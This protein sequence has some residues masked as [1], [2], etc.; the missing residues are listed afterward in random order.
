M[1]PFWGILFLV[2]VYK[3]VQVKNKKIAGFWLL[4]VAS[5]FGVLG[6]L[7]FLAFIGFSLIA[8]VFWFI[9][10]PTKINW[11]FW[12]GSLLLL[13]FLYSPMIIN[14]VKY[15]GNNFDHFIYSIK[16]KSENKERSL[17]EKIVKSTK[18]A[19]KFTMF[20]VVSTNDNEIKINDLLGIFFISCGLLVLLWQIKIHKRSSSRDKL[21]F[22]V[23]LLI[24]F[25]VFL[26]LYTKAAYSL[27]KARFWLPVF[28]L[29]FIFLALIFL[30]IW[31]IKVRSI[32]AGKFLVFFIT[33]I[34][35]TANLSAIG[36]W[37]A[38]LAVK[39]EVWSFRK[40]SSTSLRQR[41]LIT[42]GEMEQVADHI[43]SQTKSGDLIC[44]EGSRHER[45][46]H[47]YLIIE[48][49]SDRTVKLYDFEKHLFSKEELDACSSF[50]FVGDKHYSDEKLKEKLSRQLQLKSKYSTGVM[51]I[52]Q[53]EYNK[54]EKED[55]LQGE[56]V[57]DVQ[58]KKKNQNNN[59]K[60]EQVAPVRLPALF[61]KDLFSN[62]D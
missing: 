25:L 4:I 58:T 44:L 23:L 14:D 24:W 46:T 47:A 6:Q 51:E 2:A 49:D 8:I 26:I 35:L 3:T 62:S 1:I 37:Y 19:G 45:K 13:L 11:K 59:K 48:K 34:L 42:L 27:N 29:V 38:S 41:N 57:V 55:V 40:W 56:S 54:G 61:W 33:V 18:E 17:G 52:Y 50:F 22:L 36:K 60:T 5:A 15:K 28:P 12:A 16:K 30:A 20:F 53:L 21:A 32:S 7:H 43:V 10:R 39:D 31:K 9:F